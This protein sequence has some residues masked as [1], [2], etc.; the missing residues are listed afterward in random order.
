M[1]AERRVRRQEMSAIRRKHDLAFMIAGVSVGAMLA[2]AWPIVSAKLRLSRRRRL[3]WVWH[4]RLP[5]ISR[6]TS[7]SDR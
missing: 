2:I 1:P 5:V 7:E 3:P 6:A 4:H